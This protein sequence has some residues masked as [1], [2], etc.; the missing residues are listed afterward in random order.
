MT[1]RR[2]T[3]SQF[4]SVLESAFL[5]AMAE[6]ARLEILGVLLL[7][8]PAD[9]STIADEV[10]QERSVVSRHL[11]LLLDAGILVVRREGRRRVYAVDGQSILRRFERILEEA[12]SLAQDCCPVPLARKGRKGMR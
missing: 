5:R 10:P 12:R 3:A 11:K 8:G 2:T 4:V 9:V 7:H 6:P 1:T